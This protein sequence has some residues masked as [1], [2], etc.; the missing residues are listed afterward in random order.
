MTD[1]AVALTRD[2]AVELL[3]Y[4]LSSAQCGMKEPDHYAVL[5]VASGADRLARMWAPRAEGRLAELLDDL[6][7]RLPVESA[8]TQGDDTS[9]FEAYLADKL[10]EL[11]HIVKSSR[12]SEP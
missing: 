5:R 1:T 6:A 11:A 7:R 4:L 12:H 2:E 10:S 8:S 3:A 9:G